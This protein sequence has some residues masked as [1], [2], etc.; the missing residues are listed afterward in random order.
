MPKIPMFDQGKQAALAT[1]R[2]GP[3]LAAANLEAASL[4]GAANIQKA[5]GSVAD[6]AT[7][8][9]KRRQAEA[10][11]TFTNDTINTFQEQVLEFNL[12]DQSQSVGE[13]TTNY[14]AFVQTFKDALDTPD[15][16]K[17]RSRRAM[18]KLD[19]TAQS[20]KLTGIK[21][22][23][24]VEQ[25]NKV[26][27]IEKA[28]DNITTQYVSDALTRELAIQGYSE[29]YARAERNGL[30]G[31]V[32]S[33]EAFTFELDRERV[34]SIARSDAATLDQL[35]QLE[36]DIMDG[37]GDY[38][39][40]SLDERK[41]LAASLN[42]RMTDMENVEYQELRANGN[43]AVVRMFLPGVSPEDIQESRI[44]ALGISDSLRSA[45]HIAEAEELFIKT[46]AAFN[47]TIWSSSTA[48]E[49]QAEADRQLE[50]A[51]K[52]YLDDNFAQANPRVSTESIAAL[53]RANIARKKAVAEDPAAYVAQMYSNKYNK[54]PTPAQIV[55]IQRDMGLAETQISPFTNAQFNEL[56]ASMEGASAQDSMQIMGDFFGGFAE[57]DLRNL[58]MRNAMRKGMSVAQNLAMSNPG[59]V[60]S[61][62][63]NPSAMDLL[64]SVAVDD[65]LLKSQLEKK[66]VDEVDVVDEVDEVL[67]DWEK[68]VLGNAASNYM[69]QQSTGPRMNSVF[70]IK[71]SIYKLAKIYVTQGKSEAEAASA[72]ARIL[73][74]QFVIKSDSRG[75]S[76]IRLPNQ[77]DKTNQAVVNFL[78]EKL[79]ERGW[80]E[81]TAIIPSQAGVAAGVADEDRAALF[82]A[83]I[84]DKGMWQ[85]KDDNSGVILV[86]EN[87]EPVTKRFNEFGESGEFFIEYNF[88]DIL[89]RSEFERRYFDDYIPG[90]TPE[91]QIT[92][93]FA[94]DSE[95]APATISDVV[96]D[97]GAEGVRSMLQEIAK[98]ESR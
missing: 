9:E 86:D 30:Q 59:D 46:D 29:Q 1:G 8:F 31:R 45:G 93:L 34:T 76:T 87:G 51:K 89:S 57:G 49:T 23:F 92:T 72:A 84:R 58:A 38:A 5:L 73:T 83:E 24:D 28:G 79:S 7:A 97:I 69:G 88:E 11:E 27:S 21:K 43:D 33:V 18:G 20:Y 56:Q 81:S 39:A 19:A 48:F 98:R 6:V 16:S 26:T 53:E 95:D 25:T 40:Y 3:R 67:E 96:E 71:Q 60:A 65:D 17:S 50:M 22:S 47:A 64:N 13:Y 32:A 78:D 36:D 12:R 62:R 91:Q 82:G 4:A 15:I 55:Q 44:E 37:R 14:E 61:G 41:K 35:E 52:T 66:G 68:S 42:S 63:F 2:L 94:P 54:P 70:Q 85:T 10:E 80:I 74:E 75:K 77:P 90:A